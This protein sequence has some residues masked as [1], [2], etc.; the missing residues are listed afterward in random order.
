M[1]LCTFLGRVLISIDS[2][3]RENVQ[4]L[5][6]TT[7]SYSINSVPPIWPTLSQLPC[8]CNAGGVRELSYPAFQSDI[9]LELIFLSMLSSFLLRGRGR[10]RAMWED[11]I[12]GTTHWKTTFDI[13]CFSVFKPCFCGFCSHKLVFCNQQRM[14]CHG[15]RI[16]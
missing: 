10:E 11:E 8:G 13:I 16:F 6:E 9:T 7:S 1:L 3:F 4:I 15:K 2:N 5:S 14:T 12:E